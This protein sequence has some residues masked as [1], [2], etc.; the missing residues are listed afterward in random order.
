MIFLGVG[1]SLSDCGGA[2]AGSVPDGGGRGEEG[3]D[4]FHPPCRKRGVQGIHTRTRC[5]SWAVLWRVTL[6]SPLWMLCCPCSWCQRSLHYWSP[7]GVCQRMA[8][9]Q[10]DVLMETLSALKAQDQ[11]R[12][13]CSLQLPSPFPS[14]VLSPSPSL[15]PCPCLGLLHHSCQQ[16]WSPLLPLL[17][18]GS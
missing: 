12:N 1:Q 16:G 3:R 8:A 11:K 2:R 4:S 17:S 7:P 14:P 9:P 5:T 6:L 15:A 13:D 18:E 10:L